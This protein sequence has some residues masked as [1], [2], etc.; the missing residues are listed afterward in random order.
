MMGKR[1]HETGFSG[2][3]KPGDEDHGRGDGLFDQLRDSF[4]QVKRRPR[5]RACLSF[6]GDVAR[7]ERLEED[8]ESLLKLELL[9]ER[10]GASIFSV[11]NKQK[12][13]S[14]YTHH[15]QL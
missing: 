5:L 8:E 10:N 9:L 4:P 14:P 13:V 7:K 1:Q 15:A 12:N 3:T 6:D 11:F 2:T